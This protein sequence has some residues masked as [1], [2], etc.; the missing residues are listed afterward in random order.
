MDQ[1]KTGRLLPTLVP[2]GGIFLFSGIMFFLYQQSLYLPFLLGGIFFLL[3]AAVNLLLILFSRDIRV[4]SSSAADTVASLCDGEFEPAEGQS[5]KKVSRSRIGRLCK[6]CLQIISKLPGAFGHFYNRI[7]LPLQL[8]LLAGTLIGGGIWFGISAWKVQQ[9]PLFAYWHLVVLVAL[10]II[11]IILDKLCKYVESAESFVVSLLKNAR[12]FFALIKIFIVTMAAA[13]TLKML[14]IYDV[15]K[16]LIYLFIGL[17]YYVAV[18]ILVSVA[19]RVIRKELSVS[20]GIVVLLPFFHV[21]VE[22]LSVINFLEENTGITLRSLWSIK[23]VRQILP[24]VIVGTVLLLWV[25]TGIIYVESYQEGA[26]Y[27]LG[28]LQEETLSP[29]LHLTLPYP[30]D[31]TVI[32]NTETLNKVTIG[33]KSDEN[34][35]NVWTKDH[36]DSEYKLLLGSG[37]ELVSL[38]LRIEYRIDNLKEYLRNASSPDLILQAKAYELLTERTMNTDLDTILSAD[39]EE[40]ANSFFAELSA[41]VDATNTG[42]EIASVIME[43]IHPPV[44]VAKVYQDFIGVGIDSERIIIEAEAAAEVLAYEAEASRTN[45]LNAAYTDYY[46]RVS[47]ARAEV[48][49]FMA[50]VGAYEEFPDTYIYYRYLEAISKA[51]ARTDLVILGEGIDGSRIYWGNF[52]Q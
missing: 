52:S 46:G 32:Y 40:F 35:D 17:F 31:K 15:Q 2:T 13:V 38:N 1:K 12:T 4:K 28:V 26:V 33:Y 9:E 47:T 11:A 5:D 29:G 21:D 41:K 7:R 50:A 30:I 44:E 37:T 24:T 34:I 25:S 48:A 27:R 14:G 10:F 36:G 3:L 42:I 23:Y 20:P 43:S 16:Y 49:Q 39:R 45:I 51:Y 6:G 22:E 19:V 18:M 8:L